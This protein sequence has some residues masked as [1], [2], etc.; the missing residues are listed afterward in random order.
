MS[1]G[2]L[3]IELTG[4]GFS[5]VMAI[6]ATQLNDSSDLDVLVNW[7]VENQDKEEEFAKQQAEVGK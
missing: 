4:M 7:I 2:K 1:K 3:V 6:A 5:E